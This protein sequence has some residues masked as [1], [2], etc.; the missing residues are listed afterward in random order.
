MQKLY[1]NSPRNCVGLRCSIH[2]VQARGLF[3][4]STI[5]PNSAQNCMAITP[6]YL[7]HF[8]KVS[9]VGARKAGK[10]N[11]RSRGGA[12]PA[13]SARRASERPESARGA[14]WVIAF[15]LK[16]AK[17]AVVG[18]LLLHCCQFIV[19]VGFCCFVEISILYAIFCAF[20]LRFKPRNWLHLCHWSHHWALRADLSACF[21]FVCFLLVK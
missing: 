13:E 12:E 21:L 14:S 11:A 15:A 4:P 7:R 18:L 20:I 9:S 17:R 5:I 1:T 19:Q 10:K 16:P 3:R 6:F 2:A 8:F